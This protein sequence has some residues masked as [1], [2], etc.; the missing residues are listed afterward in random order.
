MPKRDVI[1]VGTS[2]GGLEAL[3]V[4]VSQLPGDLE[5]AVLV[6]WHMP[7][8]QP[9]LL[10]QILNRYSSL[11][12]VPAHDGD[13][14][15]PGRITVATPD[16]HLV[17]EASSAT[18]GVSTPQSSGA[19]WA[20]RVRSTRGPRE[21]MF[22]PSVDVLF[23]SAALALGPRVIGVVLTGMLDDGASGLYAIKQRG[24]AAVVQDPVDA[25]FSDM[26]INA[27]KAVAADHTVRLANL[28]GLLTQ[29]VNEGS[30]EEEP[31]GRQAMSREPEQM[32]SEV[33]VALSSRAL[34]LE[35]LSG[36]EPSLFTCPECHGVLSQIKEG[37]LLRFRCHTGHAF[38]FSTLLAG[39]TGSV[40]ET[41]WSAIR[42]IQESE[43][44]LAHMARHLHEA[45]QHQAALV[46]EQK[47]RETQ[48][49]KELVRQAV[50]GTEILSLSSVES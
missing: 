24:G 22:R 35:A 20:V 27:L 19:R 2:A 3:K 38:S 31:P 36:A 11:P 46:F 9:S 28:A 44:L 5:A 39:V 25:L 16:H 50:M 37:P 26:P 10:P 43:M 45:G 32:K 29:L 4:L 8:D 14:L 41:L 23:R 1:V 15:E 21:N 48:R 13:A 34:E 12:V 42:A 47:V 30:S 17:L 6:V 7:P 40:E 49:R 33:R 18:P